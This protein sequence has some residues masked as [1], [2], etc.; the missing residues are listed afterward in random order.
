MGVERGPAALRL[1]GMKSDPAAELIALRERCAVLESRVAALERTAQALHN[2]YLRDI[3]GLWELAA[4][5]RGLLPALLRAEARIRKRR[6]N[7]P[8]KRDSKN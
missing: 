1:C 4:L 5:V 7:R 2:D 6:G 8:K 3:G